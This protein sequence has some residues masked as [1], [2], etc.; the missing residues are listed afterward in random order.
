MTSNQIASEDHGSRITI[1]AR[2]FIASV[3]A[4]VAHAYSLSAAL[5]AMHVA[6]LTKVDALERLQTEAAIEA[7]VAPMRRVHRWRR[8][9]D[10]VAIREATAHPI[11]T[12]GAP[13][14]ACW[15]WRYRS[16][17]VRKQHR[18]EYLGNLREKPWVA[19]RDLARLYAEAFLNNYYGEYGTGEFRAQYEHGWHRSTVPE[20]IS[21]NTLDLG[22]MLELPQQ[23][24][25][26]VARKDWGCMPELAFLAQVKQTLD[27]A[28]RW[29]DTA[30]MDL[31]VAF[32]ANTQSLATL[33]NAKLLTAMNQLYAMSVL[34][35]DEPLPI[36][37]MVRGSLALSP[38]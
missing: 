32:L 4:P 11:T 30:T 14:W 18:A 9:Q 35:L 34:H 38:V 17:A 3:S 24:R 25:N 19:T 16:A 6:F 29:P 12:H 22:A 21:L 37:E 2:E 27:T 10:I 8:H 23:L 36:P 20:A 26:T 13:W 15:H 28:A 31:P 5:D 1:S 7:M 33:V